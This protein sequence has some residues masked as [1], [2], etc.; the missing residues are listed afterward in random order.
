MILSVLQPQS[1]DFHILPANIG[2]DAIMTRINQV[3]CQKMK[4]FTEGFGTV[5]AII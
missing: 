5:K 1:L 2:P 3:E 4:Q